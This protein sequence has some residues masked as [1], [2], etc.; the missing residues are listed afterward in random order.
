MKSTVKIML[1]ALTF[2]MAVIHVY[3]Q[4]ENKKLIDE[5]N[6]L[7]SKMIRANISGDMDTLASLYVDDIIYMPNW[8]PMVKGLDTMME[9]NKE[10]EEAGFKMKSMNLDIMEVFECGDLVIEVGEYSISLTVPN[11]PQP[12]ADNGK[13]VTIWERQ[14]DKSRKIKIE[15]WN[16]DI[17]PMDMGMGMEKE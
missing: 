11:M 8:A 9:K 6:L 13:Y 17:N 15:T 12:V 7:N 5:L 10:S 1:L 3:S 16:T 2:T 14:K 4:T